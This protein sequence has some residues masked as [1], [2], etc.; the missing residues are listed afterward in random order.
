MIFVRVVISRTCVHTSGTITNTGIPGPVDRTF[1]CY[2][3][4]RVTQQKS[5]YI[6][7]YASSTS[8]HANVI[9]YT[10]YLGICCLKF[11]YTIRLVWK[12][13]QT[14]HAHIFRR[15]IESVY[16]D[17][18]GTRFVNNHRHSLTHHSRRNDKYSLTIYIHL[19]SGSYPRPRH[20]LSFDLNRQTKI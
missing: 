18:N 20:P 12:K 16:T 17:S 19:R 3:L 10:L 14:T 4:A 6:T 15:L 13:Q 2:A 8:L 5:T 7:W 9:Q 1:Y 11:T